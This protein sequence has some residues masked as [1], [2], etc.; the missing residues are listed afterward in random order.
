[1]GLHSKSAAIRAGDEGLDNISV[2]T[3]KKDV[4]TLSH[5]ARPILLS[6]GKSTRL[7]GKAI[8]ST[9]TGLSGGLLE[10]TLVSGGWAAEVLVFFKAWKGGSWFVAFCSG[11]SP[12]CYSA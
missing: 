4:Q 3:A 6:T 5:G 7:Q 2:K 9:A 10:R 1:M 8:P 12:G 11:A